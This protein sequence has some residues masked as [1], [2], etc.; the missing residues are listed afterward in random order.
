[1]NIVLFAIAYGFEVIGDAVGNH[2]KNEKCHYNVPHK[3]HHGSASSLLSIVVSHG[4]TITECKQIC[5]STQSFF[6]KACFG[7]EMWG[8]MGHD[9]RTAVLFG[10]SVLYRNNVYGGGVLY[11]RPRVH[12]YGYTRKREPLQKKQKKTAREAAGFFDTS[13]RGGRL[14]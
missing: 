6:F 4:D 3:D 9:H 1:L 11:C 5:L 7:K 10:E 13:A 8:G 2:A 12:V 14:L